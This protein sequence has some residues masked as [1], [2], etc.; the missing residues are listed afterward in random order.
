MESTTKALIVDPEPHLGLWACLP[1]CP[2]GRVY[3]CDPELPGQPLGLGAPSPLPLLCRICPHFLGIPFSS[4]FILGGRSL[5]GQ[6]SFLG[7]NLSPS[8]Q[9]GNSSSHYCMVVT[10][11]PPPIHIGISLGPAEN[12]GLVPQKF[13]ILFFQELKVSIT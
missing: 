6:D 3:K 1:T 11:C 2:R 5:W 13:T 10:W 4:S 9:K 8:F 12:S 7:R